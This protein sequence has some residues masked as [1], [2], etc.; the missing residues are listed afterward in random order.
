M[1]KM[2]KHRFFPKFYFVLLACCL[3]SPGSRDVNG[4]DWTYCC[5]AKEAK[6]YYDA[7]SI[8]FLPKNVVRVWMVT[9][10]RSE[11]ERLSS[12]QERRKSYPALPDTWSYD[13]ALL[14]INCVDDTWSIL[15]LTLYDDKDKVI[16]STKSPKP[17]PEY[18][19][20]GSMPDL[21]NKTI[22]SLKD[23]KKKPKK[24]R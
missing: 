13:K 20:P 14:E 18:A 17:H 2:N 19:E 16:R 23:P 22:C 11:D 6:Y 1:G 21:I 12:I 24:G 7:E 9:I 4:A 8:N 15:A 5:K 3:M 10:P